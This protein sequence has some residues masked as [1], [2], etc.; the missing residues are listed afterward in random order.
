MHILCLVFLTLGHSAEDYHTNDYPDEE[1]VE[2]F[3]GEDDNEEYIIDDDEVER[4]LYSGLMGDRGN[5]VQSDDE[6]DSESESYEKVH[7]HGSQKWGGGRRRFAP[8]EEEYDLAED[9]GSE[10]SD[11]GKASRRRLERGVWG[12]SSR[13]SVVNGD[14]DEEMD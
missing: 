2:D 9:S 13:S 8:G 10:D 14:S 6:G 11:V 4:Y 3:F 5:M 7:S 1:E 12:F